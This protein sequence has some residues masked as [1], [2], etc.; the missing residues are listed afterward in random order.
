MINPQKY[1]VC[2][3][4]GCHISTKGNKFCR[5]HHP[6]KISKCKHTFQP[7][8]NNYPYCSKCGKY[9]YADTYKP[10]PNIN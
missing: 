5:Q 6:N 9:A 10:I 7:D 1:N 3:Q 8:I 4:L 2:Q